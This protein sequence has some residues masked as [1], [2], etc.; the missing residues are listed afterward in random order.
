MHEHNAFITL[1]Y[2]P[3]NLPEDYSIHKE[4]LQ[5][6]FK[7]LR[8]NIERENPKSDIKIR[9]FAC[10]EY[11]TKNN[12]PHYHAIIFGYGFPDRVLHAQSQAGD[13][14]YR[15][16]FLE[17]TWTAGFSLVGDATFQS[18]AY[19]ARYVVKKQKGK[20]APE[21][22]DLVDEGS[23]EIY[24]INKEFC[25]M[26]RRPGLGTS[27]LEKYKGDTDKDFITVNGVKM[28]LPKFY[29]TLL[30]RD[31]G[32]DMEERKIKR[33]KKLNKEDTTPERLRVREKVK[34]AQTNLLIRSLENQ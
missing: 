9:Y 19:V 33:M 25:L 29:D 20:D 5:K 31:Y 22:Y 1:T 21:Y 7:R 23:G 17:N 24:K 30:E 27:W 10:G 13:L 3:E 12:R 15:S 28:T 11:G 4:H 26:S 32:E 14:L 18:A 2:S 16:R 6:F 8:R 34:E